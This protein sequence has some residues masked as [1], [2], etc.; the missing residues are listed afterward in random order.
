MFAACCLRVLFS[1]T[2]D[3]V[4]LP[5]TWVEMVVGLFDG[6]GLVRRKVHPRINVG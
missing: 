4:F 5:L 6:C 2:L 1:W 3:E